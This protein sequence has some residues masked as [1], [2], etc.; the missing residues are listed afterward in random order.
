MI[1]TAQFTN[2]F[3]KGGAGIAG[4]IKSILVLESGIIPANVNFEKVNPNIPKD[5]WNIDFPTECMPWPD[6][7]A[8]RVSVNSFGFG[9]TNSH[10]IL[11]DAYH[12]LEQENLQGAHNTRVLVPTKH[13]IR[14]LIESPTKPYDGQSCTNGD[15]SYTNGDT[16]YTNGDKPYANG[17]TPLTNG[18]ESYTNGNASSSNGVLTKTGHSTPRVFILSAFDK[19]GLK[20]IAS[21][22]R[23]YLEPRS[24]L[25]FNAA[26]D[27]LS[28]LAYTLS[29][30]RSKFRHKSYVLASSISELEESL[31]NDKSLSNPI[32]TRHS[33]RIGFVFT[34]Q[35]AQYHGMGRQL[36]IYPVFRKSL[37]EATAYMK[38]LGGEW[39]LIGM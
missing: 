31:S 20:R 24:S 18:N 2:I 28:D 39:S 4:I 15:K 8:R 36:L 25:P 37:E 29:E 26:E 22:L 14:Q 32:S 30:R 10:C 35:G 6:Q 5:E 3:S 21:D 16:P 27:L 7:G 9:G 23:D 11:D 13:E 33:P 19:E 12:F 1:Y 17:D 38:T 34:G